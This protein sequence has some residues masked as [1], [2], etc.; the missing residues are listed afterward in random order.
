MSSH[1]CSAVSKTCNCFG[2][3]RSSAGF[4][5]AKA[6][7]VWR[8]ATTAIQSREMMYCMTFNY[9]NQPMIYSLD[10]WRIWSGL[11]ELW[12]EFKVIFDSIS[13]GE[14]RLKKKA[15]HHFSSIKLALKTIN[16]FSIE[17]KIFIPASLQLCVP[18]EHLPGISSPLNLIALSRPIWMIMEKNFRSEKC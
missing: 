10:N 14:R 17:R 3:R 15:L 7:S 13:D 12:I 8:Y 11:Y 9:F 5:G 18:S 2:P 4:E 1:R 6:C 16:S